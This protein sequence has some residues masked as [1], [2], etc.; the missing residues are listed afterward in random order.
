MSWES[1]AKDWIAWARDPGDAYWEFRQVFLF[2][3]LTAMGF[4]LRA[5]V[6][7]FGCLAVRLC[8]GFF[9]G[10]LHFRAAT[11]EFQLGLL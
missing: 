7:F 2:C 10:G 1:V 9:L 4:L 3:Y 8:F 6:C 11:L 5:T